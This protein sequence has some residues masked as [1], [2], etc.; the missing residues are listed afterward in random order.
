MSLTPR[1]SRR[2]EKSDN[3]IEECRAAFICMTNNASDK[4]KSKK[5]LTQ[6]FNHKIF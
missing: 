5:Q 2:S 1:L 6:G 4:F 3:F